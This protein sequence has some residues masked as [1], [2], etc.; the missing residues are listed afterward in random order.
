MLIANG[1]RGFAVRATDGRL[2]IHQ[3]GGDSFAIRWLAA[4]ADGRDVHDKSLGQGIACDPAGC[5]GR[6]AGGGLVSYVLSPEAYEEE[7]GRAALVIATRGDPPADCKASVIGRVLWRQ[8]GALA[9]Q[10]H[11]SAF[12]IEPT[13]PKNYDRPWAPKWAQA[14]HETANNFVD[15][16]S[17]RARD[18]TPRQEDVEAD[19]NHRHPEVAAERPSNGGGP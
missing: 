16:G 3:A 4:D 12:I 7:C 10:R 1:G 18:A 14:A 2:A 5:I 17:D 6:L 11:G 9:L 15:S 19:D 8:A 13:R